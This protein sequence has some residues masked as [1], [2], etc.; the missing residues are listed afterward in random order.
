VLQLECLAGQ[1]AALQPP[2]LASAQQCKL[3]SFCSPEKRF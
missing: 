2:H 3:L 1:L